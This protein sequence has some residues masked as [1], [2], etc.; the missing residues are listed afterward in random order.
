MTF[1][2]EE[3]CQVYA[4]NEVDHEPV[5]KRGNAEGEGELGYIATLFFIRDPQWSKKSSG[6]TFFTVNEKC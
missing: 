6:L 2:I 1:S 3:R 4:K 5:K